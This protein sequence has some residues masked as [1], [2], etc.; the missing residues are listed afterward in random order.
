MGRPHCPSGVSSNAA[1]APDSKQFVSSYRPFGTASS[2]S[3]QNSTH[4]TQHAEEKTLSSRAAPMHN[5]LQQTTTSSIGTEGARR[6]HTLSSR[7][8][9]R[10]HSKL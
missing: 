3:V 1:L 7:A 5:K 4:V 8:P 10:S 6:S 9:N 2:E